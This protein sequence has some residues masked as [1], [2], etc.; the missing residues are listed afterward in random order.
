MPTPNPAP[1]AAP[2]AG[3]PPDVQAR[4]S[5]LGFEEDD[6]FGDGAKAGAAAG[7]AADD[8]FDPFAASGDGAL[9]TAAQQLT[10]GKSQVVIS[11]R[12]SRAGSAGG[13]KQPV[14]GWRRGCP[15]LLA[16]EAAGCC[17]RRAAGPAPAG[18][19]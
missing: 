14:G 18:S 1:A 11:R 19:R 17:A 4:K 10:R 3:V 15:L 6:L 12:A 2:P 5:L 9:L 13:A 16:G 8:V 7:G